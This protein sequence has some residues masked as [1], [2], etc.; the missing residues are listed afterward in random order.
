MFF[1][2][3]ED[4]TGHSK[5]VIL[6]RIGETTVLSMHM[7]TLFIAAGLFLWLMSIVAKAV[8][9]GPESEGNERYITKGRFAQ[10]IETI[11]CWLRD[12][13]IKP[14]LGEKTTRK[15]LPYLLTVFFFIWFNNLLGLI[16]LLDLQ[17]MLGW[18]WGDSHFAII[19]GTATGNINV[20]V[21]LAV[22]A[23]VVIILHAI[24][25]LG[26]KEFFFHLCGGLLPAPPAQAIAMSP[27]I[28]VVFV[29]EL[30]GLFIKPAALAIRLFANMLAGHTLLAT[31][32]MFT[33]MAVKA[34]M[35]FF[36][37]AGV[38]VVSGL[39]SIAIYFL[40]IFVGTL[41]AFIFMFLTTV[42][43]S[44][45]SHHEEHEHEHEEV[46]EYEQGH[47][48]VVPEHAAA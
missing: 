48:A 10:L 40:E 18:F 42:F 14:I 2:A 36:G 39:G 12:E 6:L 43:I 34:G 29:I 27:I 8:A 41:Q 9:T 33:Y 19:G 5:D 21:G 17:H 22:I 45:F 3:A 31:L 11:I 38:A 47:A 4:P 20:T 32:L 1:L 24:R 25:D 16:P 44:L 28:A 26:L 7:L 35:G 23:G 30:L 37:I 15:Y 13:I 46:H